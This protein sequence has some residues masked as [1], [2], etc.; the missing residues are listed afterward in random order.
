MVWPGVLWGS[1]TRL[2]DGGIGG[3][4]L[5]Q[6]V[7]LVSGVW[8]ADL[9]TGGQDC[10]MFLR[11]VEGFLQR[12]GPGCGIKGR[13]VVEIILGKYVWDNEGDWLIWFSASWP[14]F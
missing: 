12:C 6:E 14:S 13:R 11:G 5:V 3:Y 4:C 10:Y 1:D 7:N 9:P 2:A 8:Y